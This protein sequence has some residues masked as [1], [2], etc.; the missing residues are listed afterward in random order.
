MA[1]IKGLWPRDGRTIKCPDCG[2]QEVTTS[3][4]AKYCKTCSKKR[5]AAK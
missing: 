1:L 4:T 3:R 5:K 2:A